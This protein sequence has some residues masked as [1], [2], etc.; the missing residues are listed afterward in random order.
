MYYCFFSQFLE[1]FDLTALVILPFLLPQKKTKV[2]QNDFI[3][4]VP[5]RDSQNTTMHKSI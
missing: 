5:V 2:S 4:I 3:R 1:E